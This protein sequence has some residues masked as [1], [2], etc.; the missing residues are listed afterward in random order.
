MTARA[1]WRQYPD[2]TI[3]TAGN[4]SRRP[5]AERLALADPF[6]GELVEVEHSYA[7]SRAH[8]VNVD[9]G[10][11]LAVVVDVTGAAELIVLAGDL[12]TF[13]ARPRAVRLSNV[14]RIRQLPAQE[15]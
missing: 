2:G 5:S 1:G 13:G 7:R 14:L 9:T 4:L 11:V 10:R 15:A 12:G 3:E 6:V 8:S